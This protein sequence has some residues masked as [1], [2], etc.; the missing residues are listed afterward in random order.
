MLH[1]NPRFLDLIFVYNNII[2]KIKLRRYYIKFYIKKK[3][4]SS[5]LFRIK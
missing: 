2:L 1:F 3:L 4:E 5:K